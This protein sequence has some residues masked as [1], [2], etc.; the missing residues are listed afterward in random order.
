MQDQLVENEKIEKKIF[1]S[2]TT[3][4]V[5][6][7]LFSWKKDY[8]QNN[9]LLDF[10]L[11]STFSLVTALPMNRKKYG[12]SLQICC[13]VIVIII[14][15]GY[16]RKYNSLMTQSAKDRSYHTIHR[17]RCIINY[18]IDMKYKSIYQHISSHF[19]SNNVVRNYLINDALVSN[20]FMYHCYWL[21]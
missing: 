7:M 12:T 18:L 20:I 17:L 9:G 8:F 6:S 1:V 15:Y 10:S 13:H 5:K 2:K 3:H 4:A 11:W 19:N 16:E 21:L 14:E